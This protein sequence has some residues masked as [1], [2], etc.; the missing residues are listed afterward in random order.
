MSATHRHRISIRAPER[1]IAVLPDNA[2]GLDEATH[3]IAAQ[4]WAA[5]EAAVATD[6]RVSFPPK[7][8]P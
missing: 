5:W 8:T 3:D 2:A 7:K 1:V 4:A 6:S